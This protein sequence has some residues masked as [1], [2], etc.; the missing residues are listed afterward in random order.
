[1]ILNDLV[2]SLVGMVYTQCTNLGSQVRYV[3]LRVVR[4]LGG[5]LDR[6]MI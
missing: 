1:M 5:S 3:K 4:E 2:Q 6:C